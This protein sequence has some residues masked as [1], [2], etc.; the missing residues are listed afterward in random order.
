MHTQVK[1]YVKRVIRQHGPFTGAVVEIGS[2]DVNGTVRDLFSDA[3]SYLGIDIMSGP[4]VDLVIDAADWQPEE[5]FC[6]II[7]TET[8]EHTARWPEIL[9]V[10]A[11]ALEQTGILIITCASNPR[12]PH[13]A[14][15]DK[16]RVKPGEYYSNVSRRDFLVAANAAGL[17]VEVEVNYQ[18]G[19]LYACCWL[20]EAQ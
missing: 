5:K 16:A 18:H 19:D 15:T 1:D 2:Q 8:F 14:H 11:E 12:K 17:K 10:A 3:S 9:K 4:N 20:K 6:C 7:S 13:S